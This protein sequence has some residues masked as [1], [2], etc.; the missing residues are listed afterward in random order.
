VVLLKQIYH[1]SVF[2][3]LFYETDLQFLFKI[4]LLDIP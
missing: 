2:D 1:L 3:R 4:E